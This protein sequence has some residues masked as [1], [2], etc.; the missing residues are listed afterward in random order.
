MEK[1][2]IIIITDKV[3]LVLDLQTMK[4]YIKNSNQINVNKVETSYYSQSK[5]YLKI[6]GWPY[7]MENMNVPITLDMVEKILKSNHI[8]NNISIAFWPRII[9]VSPKSDMA[10]I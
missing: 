1:S 8:F 6:I 2:G 10:I 9:K 7:L 4:K 3:V 5:S